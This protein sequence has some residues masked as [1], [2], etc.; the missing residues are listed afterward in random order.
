VI[1]FFRDSAL[2]VSEREPSNLFVG[3]ALNVPAVLPFFRIFCV[4]STIPFRKIGISTNQNL[5]G[6]VL[7]PAIDPS[8]WLLGR[9]WPQ[10]E[11]GLLRG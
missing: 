5:C 1:A 9:S 4:H 11:G 6:F 10:T 3:E 7:C 8:T 2:R